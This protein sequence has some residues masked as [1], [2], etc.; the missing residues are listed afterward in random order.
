MAKNIRIF[1]L[2]NKSKVTADAVIPRGYGKS[3]Q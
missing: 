1:S 2:D 3:G